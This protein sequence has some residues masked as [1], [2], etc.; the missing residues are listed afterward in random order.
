MET[1]RLVLLTNTHDEADIDYSIG[2]R[3]ILG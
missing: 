2:N 3:T 1:S